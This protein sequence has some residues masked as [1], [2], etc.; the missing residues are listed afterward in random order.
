MACT[1]YNVSKYIRLA[2]NRFK[3]KRG[4]TWDEIDQQKSIK[5]YVTRKYADGATSSLILMQLHANKCGFVG[6]LPG[7]WID[8]PIEDLVDAIIGASK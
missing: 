7:N 5:D 2:V 4:G 1:K 3:D 8:I 6:Q